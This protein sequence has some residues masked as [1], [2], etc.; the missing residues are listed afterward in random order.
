MPR[1]RASIFAGS[2]WV[3]SNRAAE[4]SGTVAP[5]ANGT[6]TFSFH[7]PTG[8]A[9]VPG[10]YKEYFGVVQEGTAWFSDNGQGGPPDDQIE[11]LIELDPAD[12]SGSGSA[13]GSD[14][15]SGDPGAGSG[16]GGPGNATGGCAAGGSGGAG[17]LVLL[18][19]CALTLRRRRR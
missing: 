10:V 2:D 4:I 11:A 16:D 14:G 7:G 9:C 1:D 12:G 13:V 6:F 15:S 3:A 19:A 8:D 17:A 18:A 5:G